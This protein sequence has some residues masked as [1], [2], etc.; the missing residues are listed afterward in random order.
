MDKFAV[1]LEKK[2]CYRSANH[3]WIPAFNSLVKGT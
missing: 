1:I 3:F 2:C